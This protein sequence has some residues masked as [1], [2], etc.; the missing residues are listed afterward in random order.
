MWKLFIEECCFLFEREESVICELSKLCVFVKN[1]ELLFKFKLIRRI[2][3]LKYLT[4]ITE[5]K[6]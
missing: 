3:K 1:N 5:F 6:Y 2:L 4:F